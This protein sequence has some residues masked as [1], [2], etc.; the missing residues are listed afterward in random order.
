MD[1]KR[2]LMTTELIQIIGIIAAILTTFSLIPQVLK[3]IKT[4]HARDL[5]TPT[6]VLLGIGL[7]LWTIYGIIKADNPVIYANSLS[8]ILVF[9]ILLLKFKYR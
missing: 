1:G 4:K 7:I 2:T 8:F 9:I 5:S 6:Y 3:C